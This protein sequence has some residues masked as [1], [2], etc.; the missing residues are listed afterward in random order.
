MEA[1]RVLIAIL[2]ALLNL[3]HLISLSIACEIPI[4]LIYLFG[5]IEG[6]GVSQSP[7]E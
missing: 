5:F 7:V 3:S 2:Y 6:V 1:P 4:I